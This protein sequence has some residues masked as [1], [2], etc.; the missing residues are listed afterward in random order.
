MTKPQLNNILINYI[1]SLL[2]KGVNIDP[3]IALLYAFASEYNLVHGLYQLGIFKHMDDEVVYRINFLQDDTNNE[4]G[5]KRMYK[6]RIPLFQG[7]G[8]IT[9]Y[10]QL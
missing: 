6:C 3:D 8:N 10:K 2:S 1:E 5:S 9:T 4:V 7:D